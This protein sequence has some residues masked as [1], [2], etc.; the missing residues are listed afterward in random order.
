M[1][2]EHWS[3]GNVVKELRDRIWLYLSQSSDVS[4]VLLDASALLQVSADDLLALSRVYFVTSNEVG[5]LLEG[6]PDLLRR[7]PTT[8]ELEEE[9]STERI[10][11][12]Y[13]VASNARGTGIWGTAPT[14]MSHNPLL[15][16]IRRPRMSF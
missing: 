5:Q 10:R 14:S 4:T 11:G 7:L 3:T 12:S 8:T 9:W 6:M 1:K 16:L 15:G 13:Q 2:T